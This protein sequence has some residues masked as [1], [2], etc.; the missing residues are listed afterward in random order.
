MC[1]LGKQ[2]FQGLNRRRAAGIE[3]CPPRAAFFVIRNAY[4]NFVLLISVSIV[5]MC[6]GH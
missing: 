2:A 3:R 6:H 5:E 1:G 4:A